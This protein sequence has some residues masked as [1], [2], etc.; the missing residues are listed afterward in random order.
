MVSA[1]ANALTWV[2][3][4]KPRAGAISRQDIDQYKEPIRQMYLVEGLSRATVI[5]R[6]LKEHGFSISPD[7]F[8]R[9]TR[10]WGFHKQ[11]RTQQGA[12]TLSSAA[13][14]YEVQLDRI[15]IRLF[16]APLPAVFETT[17]TESS[18]RPRTSESTV[19]LT[20]ADHRIRGSASPLPHRPA[21]R[22][23]AEGGADDVSVRSHHYL[24][25]GTPSV[26]K[27]GDFDTSTDDPSSRETLQPLSITPLDT[28]P[29][30]TDLNSLSTL[31]ES[32]KEIDDLCAEFFAACYMFERAF[33]Y[34]ARA[35]IPSKHK[36]K[37][38]ARRSR[39]LDLARTA[40]S[41]S[42]RQS[43]CAI[44]E[45]EL[46]DSHGSPYPS[47]GETGMLGGPSASEPMTAN[48][49][50]L[51]HRH[52]ARMYSY[53]NQHASQVQHHLHQARRFANADDMPNPARLP[54]LDCWTLHPMLDR[55]DCTISDEL[56]DRHRYRECTRSDVIMKCLGW[57]KEQLETLREIQTEAQR[58]TAGNLGDTQ[59]VAI[60]P[61]SMS[62]WRQFWNP[63]V[64]WAHT[65]A[66]F[67]YLW[68]NLQLSPQGSS[69]WLA[70]VDDGFMPEI[71]VTNFLMIV[72]RLIV[73]RS[74]FD[75]LNFRNPGQGTSLN[76]ASNIAVKIEACLIAIEDLLV[77]GTDSPSLLKTLFDETFC[78]HHS[79]APPTRGENKLLVQVQA[80][81]LDCLDSTIGAT[82]RTRSAT[83]TPP[84]PR[85]AVKE[86]TNRREP[87]SASLNELIDYC[88]LKEMMALSIRNVSD[89]GS[90]RSTRV[91][92]SQRSFSIASGSTTSYQ[93]RRLY[94]ST[95]Q[96]SPSLSRGFGSRASY[97]SQ[98]SGSSSL[99]RFK[100]AGKAMD[101]AR[102]TAARRRPTYPELE[103][104]SDGDG[105]P[106]PVA[107][108]DDEAGSDRDGDLLLIAEFGNEGGLMQ[109][110]P[111]V[112][113]HQSRTR[114]LRR[115]LVSL[116][117]RR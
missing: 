47:N 36:S 112:N 18:K 23:Q 21:K 9:A 85:I 61:T 33:A 73:Y 78:A 89:G 15:D 46:R 68:R 74:R 103:L 37:T 34:F 99:K 104:H 2:H 12:A 26:D 66:V 48:E 101:K 96:G 90:K 27:D 76:T 100:Q 49:S 40:R 3:Y 116:W 111:N 108:V 10:R 93:A 97:S 38:T 52:L 53:K 92:T 63:M 45:T 86:I 69:K 70:S 60:E 7:Q 109:G 94:M 54:F 58:G 35:P 1:A 44:F 95:M 75:F 8:S 82:N 106:L 87:D 64:F 59:T 65:S 19:G 102:F 88:A 105:E 22:H 57:C 11:T 43:A 39:M 77:D 91:S 114:I 51:F 56:L 32:F 29:E 115:R 113:D 62:E 16:P 25:Y 71:S 6:L 5:S 24:E 72:C 20:D 13:S 83:P 31:E 110:M 41:S 28:S 84:A 80:E 55:K 17:T 79:W 98:A 117:R 4:P 42:T 107:E 50:F 81:L 67:A 30:S 14:T